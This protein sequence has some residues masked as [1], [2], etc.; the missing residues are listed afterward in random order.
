MTK[1]RILGMLSISVSILM[2]SLNCLTVDPTIRMEG[3]PGPRIFPYMAAAMFGIAGLILAAR[4]QQ[5]PEKVYLRSEQ[6]KRL[7]HLFVV[8]C[9]YIFL[10]WAI[11]FN[12]STSIL[13]FTVSSM[14]A[15]GQNVS[16]KQRSIYSVAM[17]VMIYIIFR[18]GLK[19]SLPKGL[20]NLV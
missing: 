15:K 13:L 3:D 14:F 17:T 9:G 10:I 18:Y 4:K 12:L 11:G 19:I 16:A 6:W 5:G 7:F 1:D 2:I 8:L 20:L